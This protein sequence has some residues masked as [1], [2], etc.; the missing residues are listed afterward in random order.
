MPGTG[1]ESPQSQVNGQH[2][3]RD[4][5]ADTPQERGRLLR[6]CLLP[7]GHKDSHIYQRYVQRDLHSCPNHDK[8]P[9]CATIPLA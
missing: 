4:S 6:K 5:Q 1:L 9:A 3:F 2:Q 8:G 7:W